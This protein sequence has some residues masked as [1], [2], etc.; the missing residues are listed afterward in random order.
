M[1]NCVPGSFS[2]FST[3]VLRFCF[4]FP[5]RFACSRIYLHVLEFVTRGVCKVIDRMSIFVRILK[6]CSHKF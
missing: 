5:K 2:V 1:L 4:L 6:L 3:F